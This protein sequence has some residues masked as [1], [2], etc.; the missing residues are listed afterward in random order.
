[1]NERLKKASIKKGKICLEGR[2][3]KADILKLSII[4]IDLTPR[5]DEKAQKEEIE[6][7]IRKYK[8]KKAN[9]YVAGR[10][11]IDCGSG[12]M[13]MQMPDEYKCPVLYLRIKN[14]KDD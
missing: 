8:P 3:V 14:L 1:M 13:G 11:T 2:V 10:A 12:A 5:D 9:A 4:E 7:G 6:R